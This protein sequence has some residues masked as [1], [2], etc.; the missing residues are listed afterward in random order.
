MQVRL[1]R[2]PPAKLKTRPAG[3]LH[4]LCDQDYSRREFHVI[5]DSQL[6]LSDEPIREDQIS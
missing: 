3:H 1:A 2:R 5:C 6:V 4:R